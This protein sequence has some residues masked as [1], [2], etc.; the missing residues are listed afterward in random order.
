MRINPKEIYLKRLLSLDRTTHMSFKNFYNL[1]LFFLEDSTE[2]ASQV[3]SLVESWLLKFKTPGGVPG[4][5]YI[6]YN[7]DLMRMSGRRYLKIKTQEGRK[8]FTYQDLVLGLDDLESRI[9]YILR[10]K[11]RTLRLQMPEAMI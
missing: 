6:L 2:A 10:E 3:R 11:A 8:K 4:M 1:A 9:F 5:E 7:M